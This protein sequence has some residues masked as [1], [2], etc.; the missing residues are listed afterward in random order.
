MGRLDAR[1]TK[2]MNNEMLIAIAN[3]DCPGHG[4]EVVSVVTKQGEWNPKK[5][6]YEES[7]GAIGSFCQAE[8]K[9]LVER[10]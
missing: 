4:H 5:E 7:Y 10:G 3:R 1:S 2:T 6:T 8:L 9:C